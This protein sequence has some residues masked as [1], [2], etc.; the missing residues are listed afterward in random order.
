MNTN[1]IGASLLVITMTIPMVVIAEFP[2]I[3]PI[4]YIIMIMPIIGAIMGYLL[5][6]LNKESL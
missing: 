5:G 6:R 4:H 2:D 3:D 1:I